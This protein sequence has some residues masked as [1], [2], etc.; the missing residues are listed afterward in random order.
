MQ[1]TSL[2]QAEQPLGHPLHIG[3]PSVSRKVPA[4]QEKALSW[5]TLDPLS[6]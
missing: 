5:Q 6:K 4:G 3:Y 2:V 1:V